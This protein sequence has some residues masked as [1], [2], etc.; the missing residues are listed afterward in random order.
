MMNLQLL[1]LWIDEHKKQVAIGLIV[2]TVI[3]I[4][5][6]QIS[7]SSPPSDTSKAESEPTV[8]DL[9]NKQFEDEANSAHADDF[10][11]DTIKVNKLAF[12]DVNGYSYDIEYTIGSIT[13]AVDASEGKPGYVG[14][15]KA[16][17][18]AQ[19]VKITN[20]TS[21]KKAPCIVNL[22][23][24]PVYTE[25][26]SAELQQ[27]L[28]NIDTLYSPGWALKEIKFYNPPLTSAQFNED[29]RNAPYQQYKTLAGLQVR[30]K[31][32]CGNGIDNRMDAGAV[33]DG[34]IIW[35]GDNYA[36][37]KEDSASRIVELLK[38]PAGYAVL[39][40]DYTTQTYQVT[41]GEGMT[42][43]GNMNGDAIVQFVKSEELGDN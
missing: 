13:G 29:N 38:K 1:T 30:M 17:M 23:L 22:S 2:A 20:T 37:V 11:K 18:S 31:P 16:S 4:L 19:N 7:W 33:L 14:I 24:I 41:L 9:F 26:V 43:Y 40:D 27:L 10:D 8:S 28:S 39:Y 12:T 35:S 21:G 36:T 6:T 5:M 15:S 42:A 32:D 34:G 25:Q 3:G